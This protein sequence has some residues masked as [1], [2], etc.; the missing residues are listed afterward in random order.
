V[1]YLTIDQVITL[2]DRVL[3]EHG[4]AAGIRSHHA[5]AYAVSAPQ[6]SAF[7]EDAY[8]GLPAQAAALAFFLTM[9]HPFVDGNKRTGL[10]ALETFLDLNG[11]CLTGDDDEVA[12]VFERLAGNAIEPEFFFAWVADHIAPIVISEDEP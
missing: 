12:D 1:R 2:H 4:G 6:Q 7:G 10:A 5:L 3:T 8:A 9:N 11:Y